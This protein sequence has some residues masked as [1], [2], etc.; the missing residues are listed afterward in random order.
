MLQFSGSQLDPL[1]RSVD[2]N[3]CYCVIRKDAVH[4]HKSESIVV[5]VV[6]DRGLGM[7]AEQ[8]REPLS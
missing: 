3:R 4:T 2:S 8:H 6:D 7:T 1:I 5:V